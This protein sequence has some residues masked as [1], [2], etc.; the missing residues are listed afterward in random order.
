MKSKLLFGILLLASFRGF[1]QL[2]GVVQSAVDT[3]EV[4]IGAQLN[5]T[6]QVKLDSLSEVVF[7]EPLEAAPF[8]VIET[9]PT[10][11]LR[12]QSHYLFT[13]KY[14]LIQFDSGS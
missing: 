10:D 5:Y 13:K 14:A 2:G 4:L 1:A 11:T 8:E 3:T 9:F 12:T 6:L 7:P